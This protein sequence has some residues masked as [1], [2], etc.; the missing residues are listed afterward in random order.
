[1][2]AAATVAITRIKRNIYMPGLRPKSTPEATAFSGAPGE[3]GGPFQYGSPPKRKGAVKCSQLSLF[4][5][6]ELRF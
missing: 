6:N 4:A 3:W 1:M 2:G 5:Q